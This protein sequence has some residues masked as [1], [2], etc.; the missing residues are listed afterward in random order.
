VNFEFLEVL[1]EN[2]SNFNWLVNKYPLYYN[3]SEIRNFNGECH[4]RGFLGVCIGLFIIMPVYATWQV[5]NPFQGTVLHQYVSP[6][7]GDT[8][9]P[10]NY[11]ANP[12]YSV[13]ITK[14]LLKKNVG[15]I[16]EKYQW[17]VKWL[18]SKR[19]FVLINTTIGGSNFSSMMD[20]LLNNY[21][22]R[23]AYDEKNHLMTVKEK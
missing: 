13:E 9:Y 10:Q 4:M 18:V 14:G 7:V 6:E 3:V 17:Q 2:L 19:Y 21:P 16:A 1:N 15:N 20:Q 8:S 11:V 12:Q 5:A 23:V 22:L